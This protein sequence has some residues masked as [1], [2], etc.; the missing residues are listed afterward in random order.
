VIAMI[1]GDGRRTTI[2]EITFK[3]TRAIREVV[4]HDG[5]EILVLTVPVGSADG[6][7]IPRA[8]QW[9]DITIVVAVVVD[10]RVRI[11]ADASK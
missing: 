5:G 7:E 9:V 8:Q 4:T 3:V 11:E 6:R 2:A 1:G 10:A